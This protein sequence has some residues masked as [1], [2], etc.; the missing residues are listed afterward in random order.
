MNRYIEMPLAYFLESDPEGA[1]LVSKLP[2][3]P[4]FLAAPDKYVIRLFP[5]EPGKISVRAASI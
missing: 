5:D 3:A 4:L 2:L 1:K